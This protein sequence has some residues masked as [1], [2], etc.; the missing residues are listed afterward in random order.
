MEAGAGRD[1]INNEKVLAWTQALS[2]HVGMPCLPRSAMAI[3]LTSG[4][5]RLHPQSAMQ[6]PLSS[7]ELTVPPTKTPLEVKPFRARKKSLCPQE[8]QLFYWDILL[9]IWVRHFFPT[10]VRVENSRYLFIFQTALFSFVMRKIIHNNLEGVIFFSN[11]EKLSTTHMQNITHRRYLGGD[12]L[13][14]LEVH[15]SY[16]TVPDQ[17]A[18]GIIGGG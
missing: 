16:Q 12:L 18:A 1:R 13:D 8:V 7:S 3:I 11:Q 15:V 6:G 14:R 17:G 2:S 9:G 4:T 5:N 10:R